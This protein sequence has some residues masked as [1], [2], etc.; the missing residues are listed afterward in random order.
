MRARKEFMEDFFD[1]YSF[2][3]FFR[4]RVLVMGF[5]FLVV[6]LIIGLCCEKV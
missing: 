2:L 6:M 4:G 5:L 3:F 1:G